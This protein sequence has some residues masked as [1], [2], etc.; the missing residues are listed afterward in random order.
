MNEAQIIE[1]IKAEAHLRIGGGGTRGGG[2]FS[3]EEAGILQYSP[4]ELFISVKAGTPME[5]LAAVLDEK[6]QMLAQEPMDHRVI[7]GTNGVPTIGGAVAQNAD[8]PRRLR[9]GSLREAVLGLRFVD[10]QGEVIRAG[11]RVMKNVT[12]LDLTKFFTGSKGM[13]GMAL[14]IHMKLLPKPREERTTRFDLPSKEAMQKLLPILREPLE[15]TGAVYAQNA[16]YIRQEGEALSPLHQRLESALGQGES[17]DGAIWEGLRDW[18]A[19]AQAPEIWRVFLRPSEVAS[20]VE[21]MDGDF[22]IL[23]GGSQIVVNANE[24][25]IS[26]M[27]GL[28]QGQGQ[29]AICEKGE[30]RGKRLPL[31][32]YMEEKLRADL[33]AVFDPFH[34]FGGEN[35]H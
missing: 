7:L 23:A 11:G 4:D 30:A 18:R 35:A 20:W 9:Y 24:A 34:K 22:M 6:E 26:A 27:L 3:Y 21:K 33:K 1:A 14:D 28:G 19:L 12:G 15:I 32:N 29:F 5:E 25:Q 13:L 2:D 10:G 16:L 8:G 17:E 31:H